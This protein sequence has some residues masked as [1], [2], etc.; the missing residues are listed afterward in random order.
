L[1]LAREIGYLDS[2]ARTPNEVEIITRHKGKLD[3]A[4]KQFEEVLAIRCETDGK[5]DIAIASH[6]IATIIED[7]DDKEGA[8][9]KY[10]ESLAIDTE[11][12]NRRGQ[13]LPWEA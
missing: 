9:Y 7:V 11:S 10:E 8:E 13:A 6:D 12:G 3:L 4:K 2:A 1:D 5:P